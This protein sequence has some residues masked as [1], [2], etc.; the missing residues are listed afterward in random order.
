[1]LNSKPASILKFNYFTGTTLYILFKFKTNKK[2]II[3]Q[4]LKILGLDA[5]KIFFVAQLLYNYGLSVTTSHMVISIE[6]LLA[7]YADST[8]AKANCR[9]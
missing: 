3:I 8:H 9:L 4:N 2:L 7:I 5:N 6:S 1:M